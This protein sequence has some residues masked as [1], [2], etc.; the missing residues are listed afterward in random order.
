MENVTTHSRSLLSLSQLRLDCQWN[1]SKGKMTHCFN[2]KSKIKVQPVFTLMTNMS[3][4]RGSVTCLFLSN[5]SLTLSLPWRVLM[6]SWKVA[7]VVREREIYMLQVLFCTTGVRCFCTELA[8]WRKKV[9]LF[10]TGPVMCGCHCNVF[11]A[12]YITCHFTPTV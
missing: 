1:I 4:T 3:I 8:V 5:I 7:T 9:C 12:I 2:Q 6:S 11:T 10:D